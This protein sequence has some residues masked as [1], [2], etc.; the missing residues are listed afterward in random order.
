MDASNR[1]H[2][3][4]KVTEG[5]LASQRMR[6]G[7]LFGKLQGWS[8]CRISDL[9]IA[10]ALVMTQKRHGPGDKVSLELTTRSGESLVFLG[11]VVNIGSEH[12]LGG[13]RLGIALDE[14]EEGSNEFDF[15]HSLS[16]LYQT[17][18]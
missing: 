10:G 12:R 3:R 13:Y 16:S 11:K 9:S 6:K 4:Y 2:T 14:A 8:D 15:L 18:I 5:S 7:G 1:R 17:S